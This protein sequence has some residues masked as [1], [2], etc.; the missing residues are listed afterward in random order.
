M[1]VTAVS[2]A[3][4]PAGRPYSLAAALSVM[5]CAG[6][7]ACAPDTVTVRSHHQFDPQ[8]VT[9]V[10]IAPFRVLHTRGAYHAFGE[11]SS[12]LDRSGIPR[13]LGDPTAPSSQ[14]SRVTPVS[15]P[16]SVPDE[17]RHM[18]YARLKLNPRVHVVSP[19]AVLR[20]LRDGDVEAESGERQAKLL[21]RRLEVDAVIEGVIR[22]Y[23]ERDG[24]KFGAV[25]AAV[26]FELRLRGVRD[27]HVLWTGD[28]FEEQKPLIQDV[29]GFFERSGIFVTAEELARGGVVRLL[30]QLPLGQP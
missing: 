21:G 16:A 14:N 1:A 28:Y 24:T 19:D 29:R 15:V 23:R 22:V 20:I 25:P 4:A 11:A 8:T 13:P 2:A 17:I 7:V 5:L 18:V 26:G 12:N 30:H 27:G 10:A 9:N 3:R 6:G